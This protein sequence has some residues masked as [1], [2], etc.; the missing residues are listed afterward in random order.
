MEKPRYLYTSLAGLPAR[1]KAAGYTQ[2][3]LAAELKTIFGEDYFTEKT[4]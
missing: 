2:E 3:R 1:R 4:E